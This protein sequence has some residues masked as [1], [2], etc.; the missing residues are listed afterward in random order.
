MT[1]KTTLQQQ[2]EQIESAL[3]TYPLVKMPR[4]INASVMA[5]IKQK[6]PR[7]HLHT[8]KEFWLWCVALICIASIFISLQYLPPIA[9]AKLHIQSVL[10]YQDYLVATRWVTPVLAML[11]VAIISTVGLTFFT[12]TNRQK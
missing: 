4:K 7:P 12:R 3:K 2:D 6:D 8:T 11:V 5:K 1:P 10:L 9:L